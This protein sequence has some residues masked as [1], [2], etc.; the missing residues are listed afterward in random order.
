MLTAKDIMCKKPIT[1]SPGL[2]V[3]KL[4]HILWENR[5]GGV[6][7]VNESGELVGV[8]TE[9]DL[10]DQAKKVHIPTIITIIDAVFVL[11][12]PGKL[13]KELKKMAG[14]TVNDIFTRDPVWVSEDATVE[15]VATVMATKKIHTLPVVVDGRVVGVIGKGDLVRTMAQRSQ[16]H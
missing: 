16:W 6:P 4:A 14:T 8:V 13:E 11:E 7:V 3:D 10:I 9:S 12:K 15:E 2:T 5:I 1:V